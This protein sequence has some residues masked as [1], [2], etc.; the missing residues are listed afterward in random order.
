MQL[1]GGHHVKALDPSGGPLMARMADVQGTKAHVTLRTPEGSRRWPTVGKRCQPSSITG[2]PGELLL[3]IS[4]RD[5]ARVEL[6]RRRR[7][8]ER[9][10]LAVRGGL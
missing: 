10:A 5:E 8:R 3:F 2:A 9:G 6:L 7:S 4:G 1:D